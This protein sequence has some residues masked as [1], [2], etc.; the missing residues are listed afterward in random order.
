MPPS[1]NR[2]RQLIVRLSVLLVLGF[3]TTSLSS[4]WVSRHSLREE[5][6]GSALPLTSDNIYSE[7]QRDLLHPIMISSLM[8]HD[9]FLRDWVIEGER[10][11]ARIAKYLLE[12]MTK[13]ET[14]TSF[15]VSEATKTYYHAHGILKQV[16][17]QEPRDIWYYRVRDMEA[18][19][20]INVDPDL[21]NADAMTVFINHRVLD[22]DGNF[23]GAA[24][25]GLT[26]SF[27]RRLVED[28]QRQYGSDVYL[29]TP[30]GRILFDGSSSPHPGDNI[31]ELPGISKVAEEILSTD[32]AILRYSEHGSLV[33]LTSRFIPELE[34]YLVVAK[35][36]KTAIARIGQA[37]LANLGLCLLITVFAILL[38]SV[39]VNAYQGFCDTQRQELVEQNAALEKA[40]SE[41][42]KL[43]GLLPI[44]ASCKKI[45]DDSGYWHQIE[46][47]IREHSEADFSHG[48]CPSCA[49]EHYPEFY[50]EWRDGTSPPDEAP[51]V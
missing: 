38:T 16:S 29:L 45:R 36:D 13:Y 39:T 50:E 28:Y 11:E 51:T 26:T 1:L 37:L 2:N 12:I 7:I 47:Y 35:T 21:A 14:Y 25:V 31:R 43:S 24:G 4:Y 44:C 40:L 48:I 23:I 46:L 41:V 5:I 8:A 9:T 42:R 18:P 15:F 33:Q 20:E 27:I 6:A 49:E 17:P 19:Y 30:E 32:Q 10:D 34:W 3:L 22:Y